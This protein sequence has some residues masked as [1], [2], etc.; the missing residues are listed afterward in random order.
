M[1]AFHPLRLALCRQPLP[2]RQRLGRTRTM[3]CAALRGA[4]CCCR[5]A[6][7]VPLGADGGF[8]VKAALRPSDDTT[9]TGAP[10]A[11]ST[12]GGTNPGRRRRKIVPISHGRW[13]GRRLVALPPGRLTDLLGAIPASLTLIAEPVLASPTTRTP[14]P[15]KP[16]LD[17]VQHDAPS[18]VLRLSHAPC[19]M[20]VTKLTAHRSLDALAG[21]HRPRPVLTTLESPRASPS[22]PA[23]GRSRQAP[24]YIALPAVPR[25]CPKH[26]SAVVIHGQS[27]SVRLPSEL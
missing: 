20:A 4:C 11:P 6:R 26:R 19:R 10:A 3:T 21:G 13:T 1:R 23:G 27:R 16:G 17:P 7:F 24:S 2:A 8:S 14:Q 18:S 12:P 15:P 25:P 9:M 5:I 22:G